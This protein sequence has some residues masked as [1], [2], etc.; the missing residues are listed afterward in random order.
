MNI[1]LVSNGL[2]FRL[3]L[4]GGVEGFLK[5]MSSYNVKPDIRTANLLLDCIQE[6]C[7]AEKVI[8]VS[9]II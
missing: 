4:L 2:F 5:E 9:L 1:P 6:S 8:V 7:V 3:F